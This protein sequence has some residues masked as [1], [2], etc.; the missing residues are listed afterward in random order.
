MVGVRGLEPPASW[1]RTKRSTKLSYTPFY[2]RRFR[3]P[4]V[5]YYSAS[6]PICQEGNCIFLSA[7][8]NTV[9]LPSSDGLSEE[10]LPSVSAHRH[11]SFAAAPNPPQNFSGASV[12]AAHMLLRTLQSCVMR[13]PG[14]TQKNRRHKRRRRLRRYMWDDT[15]GKGGGETG[16]A[17]HAPEKKGFSSARPFSKKHHPKYGTGGTG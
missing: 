2:P 14:A 15:A 16:G 17:R 9:F 12:N 1:S 5:M 6:F 10:T 13:L 8:K 7:A 11:F 3:P 4:T